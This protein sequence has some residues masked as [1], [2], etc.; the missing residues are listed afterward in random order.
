[1]KSPIS[2]KSVEYNMMEHSTKSKAAC[3]IYFPA[4]ANILDIYI[5]VIQKIGSFF[6]VL[7]THPTQTTGQKKTVN[8]VYDGEKYSPVIYIKGD[9]TVGIV[10]PQPSTSTVEATTSQG[11]QIVGYTPPDVILIFDTED[12]EESQQNSGQ[13]E[14][15]QVIPSSNPQADGINTEEPQ[16]PDCKPIEIIPLDGTNDL[17]VISPPQVDYR[18]KIPFNMKPFLGMLPEVLNRIPWNVNGIKY[19]VVKVQ[20]NEYFCNKYKDGQY[21]VMNTSRRKGFRGIR[22][23][24]KCRG[25]FTCTNNECAFYLEEK[26]CN[27]TYFT[28]IG[29]QKFCFTC[30][31]LAVATPCGDLKMIEY[32]MERRLLSIYHIGD[33][34]CQ[35]RINTT[36]NNDYMKRSL[37]ELGGRVTPKELAQIQM[38]KELEKQ[39]DSGTTNM[40]AIVDIAAK[41]TNKQ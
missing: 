29:E 15:T 18:K 22:H 41:L 10:S 37:T 1:M 9:N 31:T 36:E 38:T 14:S 3:D 25:N 21:F 2:N 16:S 7:H 34:T 32:N 26:K 4:L 20:E 13:E 12:E 6:A 17:P 39:M 28:T 11:I 19:Y 23:T 5:R 27:K 8:L 24:G 33:H 40:S 30:N 35:V